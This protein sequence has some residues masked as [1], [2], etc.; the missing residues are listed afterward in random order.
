MLKSFVSNLTEGKHGKQ[1]HE[2]TS[3]P[4]TNDGRFS[5][6]FIVNEKAGVKKLVMVLEEDEGHEIDREYCQVDTS[7]IDGIY[8]LLDTVKTYVKS[9]P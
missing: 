1:L 9:N 8:D 5:M 7:C 6:N 2:F 3:V 4:L